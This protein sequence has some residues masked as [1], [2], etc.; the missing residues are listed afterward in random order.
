M[1]IFPD[2]AEL[3]T[4]EPARAL[5]M[6]FAFESLPPI[7][8]HVLNL[9]EDG[10]LNAAQIGATLGVTRAEA[11]IKLLRARQAL[12]RQLVERA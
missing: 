10:R 5:P 2:A 3:V 8:Q 7:H 1:A 9:N 4:N 11:R 12:T 6:A